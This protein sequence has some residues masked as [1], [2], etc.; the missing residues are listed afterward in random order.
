MSFTKGPSITLTYDQVEQLADQL[1]QEEQ[2]KLADKLSKKLARKKL[3]DLM[4]SMR[5]QKPVAKKEILKASKEARK[6]VQARRRHEAS[7][8]RN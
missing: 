8:G 5:P 6:H 2:F 7:A 4:D 3:L 1:S